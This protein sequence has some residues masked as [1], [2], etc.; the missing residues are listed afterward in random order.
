MTPELPLARVTVR[1]AVRDPD[2]WYWQL[3][4]V[5]Q[6]RDEG[7]ALAPVTVLVGENGS[8]KSTLVEGIARAWQELLTAQVHHWAPEPSA[9]DAALWR[10]LWLET[11]YPRPQGGIFLR[12]ESMH[13]LFAS[14]DRTAFELRAFD[15]VPLNTRSHGEGFLAFL[16]SRVTE[17]GLW[18]LDEPESALSFR[19]CLRLLAL[20]HGM[21]AAGSQVLLAT[22]SPVLAA[23]PGAT[24]YELDGSGFAPRQWG[25]LDLVQDW[26]AFFDD[27]ARLLH[28]L[29]DD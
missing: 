16:E 6:L 20:M 9:E 15:G 13:E 23:L 26:Q 5:A 17:R 7:M 2:E 19:S 21:T 29:L 18:I 11:A 8:G 28:H 27:P 1:S 12:A 14:V 3:P 10:A 24:V 22:H 25:D 4:A